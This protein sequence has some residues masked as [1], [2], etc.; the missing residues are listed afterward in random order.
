VEALR[1]YQSVRELLAE[2]HG[3]EPSAD[4]VALERAIVLDSPELRWSPPVA[5][6]PAP[7]P[8]A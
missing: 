4:L 8:A 7:P 6:D 2:E 3:V 1:A 5:G